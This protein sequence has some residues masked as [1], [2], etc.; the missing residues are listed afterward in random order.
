MIAGALTARSGAGIVTHGPCCSHFSVSVL[1]CFS[2]FHRCPCSSF[3]YE[4]SGEVGGL[5]KRCQPSGIDRNPAVAGAVS[6]RP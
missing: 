2:F 3:P 6:S 1:F 5:Q 4:Q